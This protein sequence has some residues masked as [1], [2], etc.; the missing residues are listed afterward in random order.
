MVTTA[1]PSQ[2]MTNTPVKIETLCSAGALVLRVLFCKEKR[3]EQV[4][5]VLYQATDYTSW[6]TYMARDKQSSKGPHKSPIRSKQGTYVGDAKGGL[7][8]LL[9]VS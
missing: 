8:F 7:R 9:T 2:T 6:L 5:R 1:A 4:R 3:K